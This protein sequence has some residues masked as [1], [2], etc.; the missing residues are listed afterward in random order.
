M[1]ASLL[2]RSHI[3]QTPT[4]HGKAFAQTIH[5][6]HPLLDRV[7]PPQTEMRAFE[8]N[9]FIDLVRDHIQIGVFFNNS[10]DLTQFGFIVYRPTWIAW[11]AEYEQT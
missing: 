5:S 1:P 8:A 11:I 4:C 9:E 7:D 10:G 3:A 6:D 2:G